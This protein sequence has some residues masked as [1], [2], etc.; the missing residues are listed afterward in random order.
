MEI[1]SN[2][3][4]QLIVIL[5]AAAIYIIGYVIWLILAMRKAAIQC[6][7]PKCGELL[8]HGQTVCHR[9]GDKVSQPGDYIE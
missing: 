4:I 1:F 8:P 5:V 2:P 9:C 6:G 3:G 7:N